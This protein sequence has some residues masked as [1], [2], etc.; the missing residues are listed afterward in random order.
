[1][2]N[3]KR[4]KKVVRWTGL[5]ILLLALYP[6]LTTYNYLKGDR[7][8]RSYVKHTSIPAINERM[9]GSGTQHLN[10]TSNKGELNVE[11]IQLEIHDTAWALLKADIERRLATKSI[12]ANNTNPWRF[13]VIHYN[14]SSFECKIKLR[15]DTRDNYQYGL[16]NATF[17]INL[18][19]DNLIKG[20]KK[21]S[22]IR[23][24]HENGLYGMMYYD[25]ARSRGILSNM[26]HFIQMRLN[27]NAPSVWIFQEAFH[28]KML[29]KQ[30][31]GKGII[32]KF[33]NDCTENEGVYNASG[34]PRLTAY[35]K[36]N[37]AVDSL[38]NQQYQSAL[39]KLYG[40]ARG[41][42]SLNSLL[43]LDLWA[44][45]VAIND[46]FYAHHS[47]TCHNMRLY[48]NPS[49]EKI[50]PVAWDPFSY[51]FLPYE[52]PH[53]YFAGYMPYIS[54]VYELLREDPDFIRRYKRELW[55]LLKAEDLKTY[56]SA[57]YP[58][59]KSI[60]PLLH[61]PI[62]T[63]GLYPSVIEE[64]KRMLKNQFY[65]AHPLTVNAYSK[66]HELE[67]INTS[68]LPIYCEKL[69]IGDS[70]VIINKVICNRLVVPINVA[71]NNSIDCSYRSN[72]MDTMLVE[73]AS[74]YERRMP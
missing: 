74:I 54:P 29:E 24:F 21:F 37:I 17:R 5:I 48:F 47:M 71:D 73:R 69:S 2:G 26:F 6:T 67:I 32:L 8:L 19:G 59:N 50:E 68:S 12:I 45:F 10:E 4:I 11:Q 62:V 65:V 43:D 1:M 33:E 22:L 44:E 27:E 66:E 3:L 51:R 58:L 56:L 57:C 64:T 9:F 20:C 36:K 14:G 55:E 31:Q 53:D 39:T 52:H 34:F 49:T 42:V 63:P 72:L 7:K 16:E 46:L 38:K 18:L 41:E 23:P 40:L 35:G 70:A 13:G 28:T 25:Y 15:G 30:K 60:G 61:E